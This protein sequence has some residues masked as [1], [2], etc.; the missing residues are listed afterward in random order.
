MPNLL[1]RVVFTV[2]HAVQFPLL[3]LICLFLSA[4]SLDKDVDQL[5]KKE[6][7]LKVEIILPD[8]ASVDKPEMISAILTQG[9]KKINDADFVHFEIWK[10]DGSVQYGMEPAENNGNGTYS[11]SKVFKQEGLYLIKVHAGN[12]G[13]IVFPRKQFIVG[14]LSQEELDSLQESQQNQQEEHEYHH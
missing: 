6:S 8:N 14:H 11:L 13:S 2:K 5:Y 3:L 7:P 10:K 12:E 9:G 4:C 1:K